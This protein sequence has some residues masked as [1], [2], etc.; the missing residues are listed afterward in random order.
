MY[1]HVFRFTYLHIR[2]KPNTGIRLNQEPPDI[3]LKKKKTGGLKITP[4]GRISQKSALYSICCM[5]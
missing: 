2:Q 4:T 3:Y 1:V 5:H